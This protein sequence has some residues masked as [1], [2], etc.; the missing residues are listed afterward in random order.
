[1][2]AST[3]WRRSSGGGWIV[4][5]IGGGL[6]WMVLSVGAAGMDLAPHAAAKHGPPVLTAADYLRTGGTFHRA[7][8][9][10]GKEMWTFRH[11]GKLWLAIVR[12]D[13]IITLF[14]TDRRYIQSV[15]RRDGCGNG[16]QL[17][18][19]DMAY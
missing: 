8:C 11:N 18:S 1:M 10:D 19:H 9:R 16:P 13:T 4:A 14:E 5:V 12:G 17:G 15:K 2:T 7:P 6:I 3:E